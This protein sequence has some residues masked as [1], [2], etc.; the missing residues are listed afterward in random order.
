MC[1]SKNYVLFLKHLKQCYFII[2]VEYV[3]L[4]L[5]RHTIS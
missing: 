3:I 5:G 2:P 1:D 4:N